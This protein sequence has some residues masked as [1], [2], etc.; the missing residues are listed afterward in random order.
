MLKFWKC[1]FDPVK[2]TPDAANPLRPSNVIDVRDCA[3]AHILALEMKEAGGERF[4]VGNGLVFWQDLR[5]LIS[6]SM[7]D[8]EKAA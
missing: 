1:I 2:P 7:A 6:S 3:L 4:I 8:P 5:E